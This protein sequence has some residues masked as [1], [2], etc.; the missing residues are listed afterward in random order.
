LGFDGEL[1]LD[2]TNRLVL[3]FTITQVAKYIVLLYMLVVVDI[4]VQSEYLLM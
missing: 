4:N 1:N 3:D 2:L